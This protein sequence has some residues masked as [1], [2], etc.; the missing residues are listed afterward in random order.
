[1]AIKKSKRLENLYIKDDPSI[2]YLGR[3]I[4]RDAVQSM[5]HKTFALAEDFPWRH[6]PQSKVPIYVDM[7]A[8]GIKGAVVVKFAPRPERHGIAIFPSSEHWQAWLKGHEIPRS[9]RYTWSRIILIFDERA[10]LTPKQRQEIDIQ[11]WPMPTFYQYPD[12]FAVGH[13]GRARSMVKSE[14]EILEAVTGT[15]VGSFYGEAKRDWLKI[16][17]GV[18]P[19]AQFH[20]RVSCHRRVVEVIKRSRPLENKPFPWEKLLQWDPQKNQRYQ[21]RALHKSLF[22]HFRKSYEGYGEGAGENYIEDFLT[23]VHDSLGCSIAQVTPNQLEILITDE[24]YPMLRWPVEHRL[25][26][27][28][29]ILTRFFSYLQRNFGFDTGP[30]VERLGHRAF[31]RRIAHA[32]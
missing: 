25:D 10:P 31:H 24:F 17:E 32:A 22:K 12:W 19:R 28:L 27:M 23:L 13:D 8:L 30:L 15:L 26:R 20:D 2:S 16:W 4:C 6:M 18:T 9:L 3:G 21:L 1:M 7:P 11:G 29:A 5:F 14:L